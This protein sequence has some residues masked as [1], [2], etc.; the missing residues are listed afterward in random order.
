MSAIKLYYK[1][2]TLWSHKPLKYI[3]KKKYKENK[4]RYTKFKIN[5]N[6]C[7]IRQPDA[8]ENIALENL[9]LHK[10]RK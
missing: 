5:K 3:S 4:H 1:T 8:F 9:E 6:V 2:G 10:Y 7:N